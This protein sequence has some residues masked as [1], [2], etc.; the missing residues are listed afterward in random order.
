[1]IEHDDAVF[2]YFRQ[3]GECEI[4]KYLKENQY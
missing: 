2:N 4:Q 3:N 1:M